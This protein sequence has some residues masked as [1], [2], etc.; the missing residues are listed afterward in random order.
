MTRSR[1]AFVLLFALWPPAAGG[2]SLIVD[3]DPKLL[4]DAGVDAGLD[5]GPD[6]GPDGSVDAAVEAEGR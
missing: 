6:A 5:A 1:F 2:C 3:F 4:P